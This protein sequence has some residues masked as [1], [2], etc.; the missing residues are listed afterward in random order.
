M[1]IEKNSTAFQ[2][3]INKLTD[4]RG[5]WIGKQ[6][7]S[8]SWKNWGVCGDNC[9]IEVLISELLDRPL[10]DFKNKIIVIC[11]DF[12]PINIDGT[13][14]NPNNEMFGLMQTTNLE[15]KVIHLTNNTQWGSPLIDQKR[16]N[17]VKE[18]EQNI[19]TAQG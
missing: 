18:I 15:N 19:S 8:G 11:N 3:F 5:K 17:N 10:E 2:K 9:T 1:K 6:Y 12:I 7:I 16:F 13:R 4:W 14:G